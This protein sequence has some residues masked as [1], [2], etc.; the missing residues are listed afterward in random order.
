[1]KTPADIGAGQ[2]HG[3]SEAAAFV[4]SMLP[5]LPEQTTRD[6]RRLLARKLTLPSPAEIRY[7]RLGLLMDLLAASQGE[8]PTVATYSDA[9]EERKVAGKAAGRPTGQDDWASASTLIEAY[10]SWTRAVRT[11]MWLHRDGSA[12]QTPA[13]VRPHAG[14]RAYSHDEALTAVRLCRDAIGGAWPTE[15]EY[16]DYRLLARELAG[17]AGQS[18]DRHPTRGTLARLFGPWPATLEAASARER[19]EPPSNDETLED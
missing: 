17:E 18:F 11:A 9:R 7:Q 10:G 16:D 19:A 1:M 4:A 2:G 5:A 3:V 13:S 15:S 8:V 6:L 14:K 12:S